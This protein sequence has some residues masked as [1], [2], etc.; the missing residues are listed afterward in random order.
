MKIREGFL[1]TELG[2]QVYVLPYGQRIADYC[3]GISLNETG[4]ILWRGLEAGMEK[5]E[6]A[7]LLQREYGLGDEAE[8]QIC[9]DVEH[10]IDYLAD[11][12]MLQEEEEEE[13]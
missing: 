5:G 12:G 9:R 3:E 11:M 7:S 10:F 13:V 4:E 6:L 8:A 1:K 2:G